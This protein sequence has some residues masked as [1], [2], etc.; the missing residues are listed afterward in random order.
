M[1]VEVEEYDPKT[2]CAKEAELLIVLMFTEDLFP[3]ETESV[4]LLGCGLF[5]KVWSFPLGW[6]MKLHPDGGRQICAGGENY[7]QKYE[8]EHCVFVVRVGT[9]QWF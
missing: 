4:P 3:K 6:G 1:A 7:L 9:N 2:A 8:W 5:R